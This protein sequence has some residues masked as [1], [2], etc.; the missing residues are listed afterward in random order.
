MPLSPAAAEAAG[1]A[2]ATALVALTQEQKND[3][4]VIWQ[5][6]MKLIYASLKT[7]A[8]VSVTSVSGVTAGGGIS[9]PGSGT[10]T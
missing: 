3:P 5:E 10:L 4:E 9:G 7:D 1:S 8:V 6:I 2:I